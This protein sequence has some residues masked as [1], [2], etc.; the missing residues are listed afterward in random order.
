MYVNKQSANTLQTLITNQINISV[1]NLN[2]QII[3]LRRENILKN[4]SKDIKKKLYGQPNPRYTN[5]TSV[6]DYKRS[7][8]HY[9]SFASILPYLSRQTLCFVFYCNSL[10]EQ[11]TI[12]KLFSS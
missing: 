9:Q 7:I 5:F 1:E 11:L 12:F 10:P 8:F 2:E 4:F 3:W 6:E